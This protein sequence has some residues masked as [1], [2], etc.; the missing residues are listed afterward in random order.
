MI[1]AKYLSELTGENLY[2]L[3]GA[4]LNQISLDDQFALARQVAEELV[5]L[6]GERMFHPRAEEIQEGMCSERSVVVTDSSG[7]E[8]IGFSQLHPWLQT[9]GQK[10]ETS[11][12]VGVEIGSLV[13]S[14]KHQNK[15]IGKFC[16]KEAC[17]LAGLK[18]PQVPRFVV[19]T[20]DNVQSIA[21]FDRLGWYRITHEESLLLFKGVDVLEG[22]L[23]PSIILVD[24]LSV[25]VSANGKSH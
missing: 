3:K 12:P 20:D 21:V 2:L 23:P 5:V 11:L 13:V 6:G 24:P 1:E 17:A 15:G 7:L 25:N 4:E 8:L 22:W 19:V 9:S 18:F 16:V 10:P 14:E